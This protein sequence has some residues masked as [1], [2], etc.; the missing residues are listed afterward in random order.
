MPD[1]KVGDVRRFRVGD[2]R[3]KFERWHS[4][5]TD[6]DYTATTIRDASGEKVLQAGVGTNADPTETDAAAMVELYERT[7]DGLF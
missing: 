2:Y 3:V 7:F 4:E 5:Y 6:R 1:M